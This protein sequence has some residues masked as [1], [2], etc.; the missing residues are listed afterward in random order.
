M[1]RQK[2]ADSTTKYTYPL[3]VAG[4]GIAALVCLAI[5]VAVTLSVDLKSER[6]FY[7][8]AVAVVFGWAICGCIRSMR[9]LAHAPEAQLAR[10]RDLQ[11]I[12]STLGGVG[13]A[14]MTAVLT[15]APVYQTMQAIPDSAEAHLIAEIL[16]GL[17]QMRGVA[18]CWIIAGGTGIMLESTRYKWEDKLKSPPQREGA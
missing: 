14:V 1:C 13:L 7:S 4:V 10:L 11:R 3:M 17:T 6:I 15:I 2:A 12:L 5:S 9:R 18:L 16:A 8:G